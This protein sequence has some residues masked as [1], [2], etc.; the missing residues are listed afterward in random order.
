MVHILRLPGVLGD[1]A[2]SP[3]LIWQIR[4]MI[5]GEATGVYNADTPF[6]NVVWVGG[7]RRFIYEL[8]KKSFTE[9]QLFFWARQGR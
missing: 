3:W 6:N 5:Q 9:H 2:S 7:L 8:L 1:G 4:K